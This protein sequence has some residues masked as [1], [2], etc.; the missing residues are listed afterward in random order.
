ML[1][2]S[3]SPHWSWLWFSTL[4]RDTILLNYGSKSERTFQETICAE[5]GSL[6]LITDK[7]VVKCSSCPQPNSG[8]H[9][10][11][12]EG[13]GNSDHLSRWVWA[14]TNTLKHMAKVIKILC[15]SLGWGLCLENRHL[16]SNVVQDPNKKQTKCNT[17]WLFSITVFSNHFHTCFNST[18]TFSKHLTHPAYQYTMWTKLWILFHCLD[19]KWNYSKHLK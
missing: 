3:Q 18:Y 5:D 9:C 11:T 6:P 14:F 2:A 8:C 7:I 13:E 16:N 19:T 4:A 17:V 1:F 15:S 10:H 12:N